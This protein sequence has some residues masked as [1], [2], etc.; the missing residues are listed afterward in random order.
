MRSKIIPVVLAGVV[1]LGACKNKTYEA[2]QNRSVT[3]D[4]TNVATMADSVVKP[5]LVKTADIRF[6]VKNVQQTSEN[7]SALVNQCK[8]MVMHREI[9]SNTY[10]SR[11]FRLGNDSVLHVSSL[12]TTADITI[13]LPVSKVD[14]FLNTVS[15]NSLYVS[16]QKMDIQDKSLEYLA[17]RLK[18]QNR[19]D[20]VTRQKA[21]KVF[22]KDATSVM[23]MKDDLV[24]EQI[25][26][27]MIDD[28]ARF[29]TITLSFY[30]SNT[31]SKEVVVNDDP[32]VYDLP[33][34]TRKAQ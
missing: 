9:S 2:D 11:D 6:K 13:K 27:K 32:A 15:H 18:A 28:E 1:L 26:N 25:G 3:A 34:T 29:S 33:F 10:Q 22:I 17:V 24:D 5:K 8:G 16:E 21:G 30:Q 7:I 14:S 23:N 4:S 12:S 31:V 19:Q 20:F